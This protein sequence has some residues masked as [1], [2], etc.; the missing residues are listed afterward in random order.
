LL[1]ALA[2]LPSGPMMKVARCTAM[3][4]LPYIDFSTQGAVLLSTV[5]GDTPITRAPAAL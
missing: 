3:Y 4:F 5:S 1:K 2:T